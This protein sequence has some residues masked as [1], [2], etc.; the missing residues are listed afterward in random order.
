MT[1]ARKIFGLLL[2]AGAVYL[3]VHSFYSRETSTLPFIGLL[4]V[5]LA[6]EVIFETYKPRWIEVGFYILGLLTFV[7]ALVLLIVFGAKL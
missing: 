3:Y 1:L 4:G 7:Y 6:I 2:L 5:W